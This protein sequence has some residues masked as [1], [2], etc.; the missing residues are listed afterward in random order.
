MAYLVIEDFH[1]GLDA[2]KSMLSAPAGTLT[3]LVN[4]HISTGGEIEKRKAFTAFAALAI[5]DNSAAPGPDLA[6][7]GLQPVVGGLLTFG[8]AL[9]AH[10]ST[11]EPQG[12][13]VLASA[14]PATTPTITYQQLQHPAVAAGTAYDRSKHRMT[15]VVCSE[16]FGGK[17]F[18]VAKF[19][20]TK[21]YCFYDGALA[22]DFTAGL[23][24]DYLAANPNGITTELFKE[25]NTDMPD[26]YSA[27]ML[28]ANQVQLTGP[29]AVGKL[30]VAAVVT[31][32]HGRINASETQVPVTPNN[33]T[34]AVASFSILAG[35]AGAANKITS[36][37][38][39]GHY[40][41]VITAATAGETTFNSFTVD[42]VELADA[43]FYNGTLNKLSHY[44]DLAALC[45][46]LVASVNSRTGTTGFT[47]TSVSNSIYLNAGA[48]TTVALSISGTGSGVAGTHSGDTEILDTSAGATSP[49]LFGTTT[50]ATANSVAAAINLLTP[51]T[52]YSASAQLNQVNIYAAATLVP[53]PTKYVLQVTAAGN[54]CIGNCAILITAATAGDTTFGAGSNGTLGGFTAGGVELAAAGFYNGTL[55]K[56]S[57]YAN[58]AALVQALVDSVNGRTGTTGYLACAVGAVIYVSKTVTASSDANVAIAFAIQGTGAS[59]GDNPPATGG[60][61]ACAVPDSLYQDSMFTR[62]GAFTVTSPPATA[63]GYGGSGTY[64]YY[65]WSRVSGDSSI[66]ITAPSSATTAFSASVQTGHQKSAVFICTI[67]DSNGDT[68]ASNQI[69]VT[70]AAEYDSGN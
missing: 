44:A 30:Q 13:P 67:Q 42:A 3:G 41:A 10:V 33:G 4:A 48:A 29:A 55:N 12:Q 45:A 28:A 51:T 36:V 9:P 20:D 15:A 58:L 8:S 25:L 66:T 11:P 62:A 47:A 6:T 21:T 61:L 52:S 38:V 54:V 56:L 50:Q 34:P 19:A 17:A 63:A 18:V 35:S 1:G 14:I 64:V 65:T 57:H 7:F 40:T 16:Q 49:V 46:A 69:T 23:I 43:G 22:N 68:A 60:P 26:G 39:L 2:R 31:S 27:E 37:K 53:I 70:L 32:D 5:L 59:A 24:L